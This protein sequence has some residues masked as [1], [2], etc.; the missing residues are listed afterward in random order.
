[1]FKNLLTLIICLLGVSAWGQL[2]NDGATIVIESGATLVVEGSVTNNVN[3]VITNNGT[4]E[5]KGDITHNGTTFDLSAS[6]SKL[7]LSGTGATDISGTPL[8]AYAVEMN[9]SGADVTLSTGF[10]INNSLA[11]LGTNN[12][13]LDI[14]GF[15]LVINGG[16]IT[17][18]FANNSHINTSG[19][20]VIQLNKSSAGAYLFP[21]GDGTSYTPITVDASSAS[22]VSGSNLKVNTESTA[23]TNK[24]A[25][26]D[27]YLNR[28][29]NVEATNISNYAPTMTAEYAQS[30]VVLTGGATEDKILG[31]S[32]G[33]GGW[34]YMAATGDDGTNTLTGS[35]DRAVEEFTGTN[36]YG[37]GDFKIFFQGANL[38]G[39]STM[40]TAL[41]SS[42]PLTS[43]YHGSITAPSIPVN[44]VDWIKIDYYD[45]TMTT[46]KGSTSALVL[47]DGTVVDFNNSTDLPKFKDGTLM[48][49][50]VFSHR[51]HMAFRTN[52]AID[53]GSPTFQDF[54]SNINVYV[55]GS[56]LTNTPLNLTN[57][58]HMMWCGDANQS[59]T[60]N[61]TDFAIVKFFSATTPS[62]YL[63]YD[64][65]FSGAANSTDF[66]IA[67]AFTAVTKSAHQ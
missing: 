65:N 37:K 57:G 10:T 47:S 12:G 1:M 11:F 64:L 15:D 2:I 7:I 66:S 53:T 41:N 38:G 55:D 61:S 26:A 29:W 45:Q 44:A 21:V 23:S 8:S 31:A 18:T 62:G 63:D 59:A 17:G 14:A 30:D 20:G 35:V 49:H 25:D 22:F 42:I 16:D 3:G 27:A 52:A 40:S 46:L 43:P 51:N 39:G 50:F 13:D 24:P 28:V 60:I 67:R 6:T 48:G 19:A 4:L 9:K 32:Y 34:T 54:T 36:F 33:T 58:K 5:V 56:I